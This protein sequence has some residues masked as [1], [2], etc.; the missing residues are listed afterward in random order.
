MI[1]LELIDFIYEKINRN[2]LI[3]ISSENDRESVYLILNKKRISNF[4]EKMRKY[5]DIS[6]LVLENNVNVMEYL[7]E[8]FKD[9]KAEILIDSFSLLMLASSH[10][11][12]EMVKYLYP[13]VIHLRSRSMALIPASKY[14]HLEIVKYLISDTVTIEA[15]NE[16]LQKA[17]AQGHLKIVKCLIE[18]GTFYNIDKAVQEA[19]LNEHLEI[20][21]YLVSMGAN[22][23]IE[24]NSALRTI[25]RRVSTDTRD[26][27]INYLWYLKNSGKN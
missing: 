18:M 12:L 23:T 15:K 16:A 26:E 2:L 7:M 17:S 5:V 22:T 25:S 1:P 9:K 10:G 11:L 24:N 14:G 21:K 19:I 13:F 20:V 6:K 4:R 8:N 3:K 27:I